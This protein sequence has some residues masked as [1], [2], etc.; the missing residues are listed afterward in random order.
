MLNHVMNFYSIWPFF[1]CV[2]LL[3]GLASTPAFAAADA[4]PSPAHNRLTTLDG[5]RGFLALAVVFHHAAIY[6]RFLL[7][8]RWELPPSKFYT[9]LGQVGVAM[10]FMVTGYLFWSRLIKDGGQTDWL[11]LFVGRVFRIGPLYLTA[12]SAMLILVFCETDFRITVTAMQLVRQ[13][14]PWLMLGIL[15]GPNVNGY[16]G[17]SLLLAGVNWTLYFEWM[18]YLSL[19][20][21]SFLVIERRRY[22]PLILGGFLA[23][24]LWILFYSWHAGRQ[25]LDLICAALFLSGMACAWLHARGLIV[26][27]P[28]QISSLIVITLLT[29]TFTVFSTIYAAGPIILL[30]VTFY[31]IASGCTIFGLL[32]S[33]PARRLGDISY[34]IYLLQ[35]L[36][37]AIVFRP[38]PMRDAALASPA[39]HWMLT[40]LCTAVLVAVATATHTIIER[41]G[42]AL[43]RKV[44]ALLP[45]RRSAPSPASIR[46]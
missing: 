32:V 27:I 3:L 46:V 7:D 37:L 35:G 4:P 45:P 19:P 41:P 15:S 12:I 1:V 26:P 5:L 17:T 39:Q 40:L 34:G 14:G 11:R 30:G 22:P 33:R 43:G 18:F 23:C 6:H 24:L 9:I 42:I 29:I 2:V 16:S 44:A 28:D 25:T 36:V 13:V 38:H 21:M 31:L 8:G 10:F 20:I